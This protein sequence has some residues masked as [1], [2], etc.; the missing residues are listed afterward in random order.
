MHGIHSTDHQNETQIVGDD[1][2]RRAIF[3]FAF[4]KSEI[5]IKCLKK[6]ESKSKGTSSTFF[7]FFS[8]INLIF[9]CG[10]YNVIVIFSL[11]KE[12]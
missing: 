3:F 4:Q 10:P 8:F 12:T 1:V 6:F 2:K 7:T 11:S 9:T 5:K